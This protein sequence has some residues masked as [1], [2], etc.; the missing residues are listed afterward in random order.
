M[1]IVGVLED[2]PMIRQGWN[3][4]DWSERRYLRAETRCLPVRPETELAVGMTEAIQKMRR[5]EIGLNV[6]PAL[7][8]ETIEAGAA[9]VGQG[10]VNQF[11][12]AHVETGMTGADATG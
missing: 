4:I 10:P 2:A 12:R 5:L 8:I 3:V 6:D 9:A 7:G 11:A 1:T